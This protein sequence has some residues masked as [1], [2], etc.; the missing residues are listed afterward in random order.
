MRESNSVNTVMHIPAFLFI[1]CGLVIHHASTLNHFREQKLNKQ[2]LEESSLQGKRQLRDVIPPKKHEYAYPGK[3]LLNT[4]NRDLPN[5]M[6]GLLASIEDKP[7][8]ESKGSQLKTL[9]MYRETDVR[10]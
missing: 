8:V 5:Q 10:C 2:D 1:F 6:K 4:T 3:K 9:A 7:E